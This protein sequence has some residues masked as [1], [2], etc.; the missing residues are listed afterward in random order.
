LQS[1]ELIVPEISLNQSREAA[2]SHKAT[3]H[4]DLRISES[5]L[6]EVSGLKKFES[7]VDN[8]VVSHFD[9]L[10]TAQR[11]KILFKNAKGDNGNMDLFFQVI[12]WPF[13]VL[14]DYTIPAGS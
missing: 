5:H 14:R 3:K 7:E 6:L 13:N 1:K 4:N 11:L 2:V 12:D 9:T 8:L 10:F